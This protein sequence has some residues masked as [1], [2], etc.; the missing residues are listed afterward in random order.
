MLEKKAADRPSAAELLHKF[1]GF[2]KSAYENK[3]EE[4]K[5][6]TPKPKK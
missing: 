6:P 2:V 5:N 1:P 4:I 3:L